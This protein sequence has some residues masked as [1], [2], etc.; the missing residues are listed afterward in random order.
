MM[1]ESAPSWFIGS[2]Q[3]IPATQ[4]LSAQKTA[5]VECGIVGTLKWRWKLYAAGEIVTQ[6]PIR[7]SKLARIGALPC[8]T[9]QPASNLRQASLP[10]RSKK[11]SSSLSCKPT[12]KFGCAVL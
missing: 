5:A 1:C 3:P 2:I 11:P 8:M 10:S 12:I 7:A 9:L 6:L 4:N